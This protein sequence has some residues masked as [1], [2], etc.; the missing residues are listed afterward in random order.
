MTARSP[1]SFPLASSVT[2]LRAM[3]RATSRVVPS[4]MPSAAA[5]MA[6][7]SSASVALGSALSASAATRSLRLKKAAWSASAPASSAGTLHSSAQTPSSEHEKR[8]ARSLRS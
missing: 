5:A 2:S 8:A 3:A 4:R 1:S 7:S 6:S